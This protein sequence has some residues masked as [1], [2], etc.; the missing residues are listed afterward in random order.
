MSNPDRQ[1]VLFEF[2]DTTYRLLLNNAARRNAEKAAG[3]SWPEIVEGFFAESEAGFSAPSYTALSAIF[4]GATRKLSSRRVKTLADVDDLMDALE[5]YEDPGGADAELTKSRE[6]FVCLVAV[7]TG[8]TKE[9]LLE[10]PEEE[11]EEPE[12]PEEA[13]AGPD[14]DPKASG[15]G[16]PSRSGAGKGSSKKQQ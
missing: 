5:D 2:D 11:P 10:P 7:V 4:Y 13:E 12:E 16:S 15:K 6:L 8:R 1:P 14:E 9:E 3:M